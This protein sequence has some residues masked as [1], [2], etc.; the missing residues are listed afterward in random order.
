LATECL[1]GTLSHLLAQYALDL[2]GDHRRIGAG[3]QS[4]TDQGAARV[5]ETGRSDLD[6]IDLV[7]PRQHGREPFGSAT[8]GLRQSW[9]GKTINLFLAAASRTGAGA[10]GTAATG[11]TRV[12]SAAASATAAARADF[13]GQ[14]AF[15]NGHQ[16]DRAEDS[17]AHLGRD[18][19]HGTPRDHA[20]SRIVRSMGISACAPTK[21]C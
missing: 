14:A 13:V 15:R 11:G 16:K 18:H 10:T 9:P 20:Q 19:V 6:A 7:Q 4:H 12:L 17:P 2:F 8:S 5:S 1:H 21:P 3:P